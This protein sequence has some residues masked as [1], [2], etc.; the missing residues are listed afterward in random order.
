MLGEGGNHITHCAI[1][2]IH[3]YVT[4][5]NEDQK[6]MILDKNLSK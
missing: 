6:M 4:L 3:E 1:D 5:C 2:P